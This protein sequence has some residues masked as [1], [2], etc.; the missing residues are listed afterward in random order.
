MHGL[1]PERVQATHIPVV[2]CLLSGRCIIAATTDWSDIDI[3]HSHWTFAFPQPVHQYHLHLSV[4]I[5]DGSWRTLHDPSNGTNRQTKREKPMP[6]GLIYTVRIP[7]WGVN[8]L[9]WACPGVATILC[10]T[11]FLHNMPTVQM[12]GSCGRNVNQHEQLWT[13][14]ALEQP[15]AYYANGCLQGRAKVQCQQRQKID[16]G[17]VHIQCECNC[18]CKC[19][20]MSCSCRHACWLSEDIRHILWVT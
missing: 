10:T 5:Q 11:Q 7:P 16:L 6:G 12:Q 14:A 13:H 19:W 20:A 9:G 18:K 1:L 17:K 3:D 8:N 2:W 4:S 15:T